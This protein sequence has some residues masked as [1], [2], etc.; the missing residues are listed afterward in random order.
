[1]P[2]SVLILDDDADF[3]SLLTDIFEQADYIVTS[4]TD[5]VEAVDAFRDTEYDLV[6]TDHKMPEMTGAEFM[7]VIKKI[8]PEVPVIMVSGYLENDT[9]RELISEGVGGV[10]LKPLNIFSLLERTSELIDEAKKLEN[11][12][13]G[14][15]GGG[16]GEDAGL[17]L[18]FAFRSYPCKSG[19]SASF[20]ERLHSL[21][22][23]KSTLSLIGETGMHYRSICEDI[24]GFYE[25]DAE[26]FIYLSAGSFDVAQALSLI[27]AA[28]AAGADR[29]TCVLLELETMHDSQKALATELAKQQGPFEAVDVALRTLF[30]V[31]GDLDSLFDEE[32]ID[33][34]LYILMGTAEVRVP[35]LRECNFDVDIMAQQLVVEIAREKSFAS[36]PRLER[37]ARDLFRQ[38]N[39][40]RNYEELRETARKIIENNPG[41]V[42]THAAVKS[43]LR[44]S[45]AASPRACFESHLSSQQVD[46]LRAGSVLFGGDLSKTASFFGTDVNAIEAKMK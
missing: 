42:I 4:L 7:K 18:G 35:P 45:E 22:N 2:H 33:E 32:L 27:E 1:M 12:S 6:V 44:V 20:A 28:Q 37:S 17:Q 10:F 13:A 38:H 15:E 8:R 5:P 30:C 3:N 11:S 39:W 36:V 9:I 43:A 21:R 34:N 29:V 40:E 26:H 31:S 46:Y 19:A 25:S 24:R 23:F 14:G 16:E 41:D